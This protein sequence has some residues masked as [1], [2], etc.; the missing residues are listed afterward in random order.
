MPR[1]RSLTVVLVSA[2]AFVFL[3]IASLLTAT[4]PAAAR[5]QQSSPQQKPT[6]RAGANLV[7]VDVYPTKAGRPVDDL[8]APEFEILEDGVPQKVDSFEHVV[9]RASGPTAPRVEP[10]TAAEANQMAGDAR[11]RVFVLFLDTYHVTDETAWHDGFIRMPGSTVERKPLEKKPLG[12]ARIDRALIGFLQKTVAPTDL[13]ALMTPEMDVGGLTFTRR[14]ASLEEMLRTAWARRFSSDDLDPEEERWVYCY[15]PDCQYH[16]WDGVAEEMIR[17][18][19][20]GLALQ[21]LTDLV[22]RLQQL[23]EERKAVIVVSEGWA[24]F[25]RN[26]SLAR[27][28][29]RICDQRCTPTIPGGGGIY[30]DPTGKIA[31]GTDPRTY[32]TVDW[33]Q[34]ES[35]RVMLAETDNRPTFLN[36]ADVAN[37]ANVSFYPVDPRG[38]AALETP[39]D[40]RQMP[41]ASLNPPTG[42]PEGVAADLAGLRERLNSLHD[43]ASATDGK[44]M[45]SSNDISGSLTRISEDL[46]NYYLIGYYSTNSRLDGKFRRI[47]VRVKRPGVDVRAR[48]GYLAPTEAELKSW[49][50][51]GRPRDAEADTRE[52]LFSSLGVDRPDRPFHVVAGYGWDTSPSTRRPVLWVAG[53]LESRVARAAEWL[54]GGE[55]VVTVSAPGGQLLATSRATIGSAAPRFVIRLPEIQVSAGDYL[56]RAVL[57]GKAGAATETGDQVRLAVPASAIGGAALFGQPIVFRRGP[58]S[59]AGWQ[60]TADVRFRKAERIRLEVPLAEPTAQ[61]EARL[62]DRKGQP[63][64]LPLTVSQKDDQGARFAVAELTLAPLAPGDYLIEVSAN[65]GGKQEKTFAAFRIVP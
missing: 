9:V 59:G 7:R 8:T 3:A 10:R 45:V 65:R 42:R 41:N 15:Q 26:R 36:L 34:C 33:Q 1:A 27:P 56:V 44:A 64:D 55:A 20:E 16:C 12:P 46:S 4:R 23:R 21:R 35:A 37:R 30:V 43:L 50:I 19:R 24:L 29:A 60:P 14:P 28:V 2:L 18:R 39:I 25:G 32:M 51:S 13:F 49:E 5:S 40:Y 53:E 57:R 11:N 62:L 17:R 58:F 48:R 47:A 22:G 6:F 54:E 61:V 31:S 63:R 52:A 38:L